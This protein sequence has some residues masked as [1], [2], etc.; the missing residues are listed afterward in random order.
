MKKTIIGLAAAAFMVSCG[1]GDTK[2]TDNATPTPVTE[3]KT[4]DLSSNPD[5]KKG[6]ALIGQ[7]DCL[8]CHKVNETFT[9]PA[10]AEVAK[11]YAGQSGGIVDTL[12][13]R[14]INGH[15]GTWGSIPMT[16]HKDLPVEDAEAM[17]RYVLLLNQQ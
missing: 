6:L 14:I 5:Y 9:G 12:A 17:V 10:Y 3:T 15:V 2:P 1:N 4:A 8:T 16:S 11:K 13:Q 7:S